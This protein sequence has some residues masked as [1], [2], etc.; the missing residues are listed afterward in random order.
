[1][2]NVQY[3]WNWMAGQTKSN[4]F[5]DNS[6]GS[7]D[8]VSTGYYPGTRARSAI[9]I[10]NTSQLFV[11]GGQAY[12]TASDIWKTNVAWCVYNTTTYGCLIDYT[13]WLPGKA[14]RPGLICEMMLI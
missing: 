7:M 9:A 14:L 8:E 1:M 13:C 11:Y 12:I 4:V 3:G 5:I 6:F 2:W 10:T